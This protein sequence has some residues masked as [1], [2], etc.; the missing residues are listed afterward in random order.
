MRTL[1]QPLVR[2]NQPTVTATASVMLVVSRWSMNSSASES[3]L[4][5]SG[6][7]RSEDFFNWHAGERAVGV[8]VRLR[9]LADDRDRRIHV[10]VRVEA[11]RQVVG[12]LGV[13][14]QAD[15]EADALGFGCSTVPFFV[16][17]VFH[18]IPRGCCGSVLSP[19]FVCRGF[20]RRW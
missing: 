11:E 19:H 6:R 13:V 7:P 2:P 12:D 9:I 20:S 17:A 18:L 15:V 16:F 14:G 10:A 8:L 5:S 4:K 3:F 1:R